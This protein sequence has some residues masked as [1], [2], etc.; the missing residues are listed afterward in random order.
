MAE[1]R[2]ITQ[3]DQLT[4]YPATPP[5][6]ASPDSPT[7]SVGLPVS[8]VDKIIAE[9]RNRTCG[10][11]EVEEKWWCISLSRDEFKAFEYDYFPQLA[12]FVLRMSGTIHEAVIGA[13]GSLVIEQLIDIQRGSNRRTHQVVIGVDLEYWEE[14]GKEA[15]VTVWRPRYIEEDGEAVLEAAETETGICRAV[16]GSLVD[17]ERILRIGLKDFGYW[18]DCLRIDDIPGE[19]AI[20]FSQLYEIVQEA[21]AG[22]ERWDRERRKMQHENHLKRPRVRSPPQQLTESDEERFKAAEKRVKM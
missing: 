18:P 12:K 2:T 9:I 10:R 16:D 1:K 3:L 8:G 11:V 4:L 22:A 19:I 7:P 15:R 5:E 13:F 14:K 17:G 6:T 20:S 21:E